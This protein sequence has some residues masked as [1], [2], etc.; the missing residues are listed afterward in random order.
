M[1][2]G[3]NLDMRTVLYTL[4]IRVEIIWGEELNATKCSCLRDACKTKEEFQTIHLPPA[5]SF[6]NQDAMM[7]KGRDIDI[8][9]ANFFLVLFSLTKNLFFKVPPYVAKGGNMLPLASAR[10]L[11]RISLSQILPSQHPAS[12]FTSFFPL[13]LADHHPREK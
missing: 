3:S 2:K 1:S 5:I 8:Q 7:F 13:Q 11:Q 6:R 10:Q 9:E 4:T 12:C